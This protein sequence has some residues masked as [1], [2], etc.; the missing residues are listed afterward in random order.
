MLLKLAVFL[1]MK[2]KTKNDQLSHVFTH[3]S[4]LFSVSLSVSVFTGQS[5][6]SMYLD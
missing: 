5:G 4:H 2:D 3:F 1:D 6:Y